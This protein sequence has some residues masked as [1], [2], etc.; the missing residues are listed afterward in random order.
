M[1]GEKM[2][3][4]G[5]YVIYGNNGACEVLEVGPM[6]MQGVDKSKLYYTLAPVYVD[7]SKVFT[8]VNN[9]KVF[10]R[11]ILSKEEAAELIDA[12]PDIEQLWVSD[13]K[14]REQIYREALKTCDCTVLIKII[15]TLYL[16]RQARIDDGKKVT[17]LD[18]RYLKNAEEQLY[19][20]LALSLEMEKDEMEAYIASRVED[21]E[22][23]VI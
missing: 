4:V 10:M 22:V 14:S 21:L 12:I 17:A 5:D 6:N 9:K 3:N 7:G 2:F 1:W 8:P 11:P 18:E 16:R 23:E 13:E 19:G 15:K 20:E